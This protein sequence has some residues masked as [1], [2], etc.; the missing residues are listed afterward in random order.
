MVQKIEENDRPVEVE[1]VGSNREM[2]NGPP[3]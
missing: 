3:V 2:Q 1:V